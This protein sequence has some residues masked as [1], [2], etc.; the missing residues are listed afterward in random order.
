MTSAAGASA[1]SA[2]NELWNAALTVL[3]QKYSKPVYKTW[4]KPLRI[5]EFGESEI[6][7]GAPTPF[8]RDWVNNRLKDGIQEALRSLTGADFIMRFIVVQPLEQGAPIA[9]A[10]P[11]E[12]TQAPQEASALPSF[13]STAVESPSPISMPIEAQLS[14]LS[15][16]P[17]DETRP[18]VIDES[19]S[20]EDP[21]MRSPV[22]LTTSSSVITSSIP[23]ETRQN[24]L[25]PRYTF[26]EF[27]VGTFN[28]FAHAA[29]QAVADAPARAY[30]PL[31]LY[32]GV[33]LG[34]THLMHAVGHHV[35]AGKPDANIVY[36][37][38]EKFTNDFIIAIKNN[39][40]VE[41]RSTYRHV[42]VLMIDDIQFLEGKEQTQEEFFHTFNSLHEAGKQIIISSDRPP[43][44][45]Q[46]LENR[47]RSRFEWG[48]LIDVQ[49]PDLETREAILRKKAESEKLP[50][51]DE[52]TSY[53]ARVIPSNIRELEGAL[54][55]VVA[56]A[57]LTKA[58]ITPELAG[59]VLKIADTTIS[60]RVTIASIKEQVAKAHGLS[61]KDIDHHRRDKRVAG[62]RQIAMYLASELTQNSLPQIAREFQKKD[63]TTVM[64]ARDRV[65]RLMDA[66]DIYRSKIR[67]LATICRNEYSSRDKDAHDPE[68]DQNSG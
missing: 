28:S 59:Q 30:N 27:V 62:P 16:A 19:Q 55:R 15:P 49:P 10:F 9:E 23:E 48:L 57:S 13:Q 14:S 39:Q 29:A 47:L 18:D 65:K 6:V 1:N 46:T 17:L 5:V 42:D 36:V 68:K 24:N 2:M 26:E 4:L 33:G 66:D 25:N 21:L 41:F 64:Y 61:V 56:Y 35:L 52:V 43:K 22:E 50:V 37:S 58:P 54:I 11:A 60:K 44:E 34:K 53:I 20:P 7:L 12:T 45:I 38:S 40:A 31:F 51:P 32:G 8:A 67:S 3:E 63:H